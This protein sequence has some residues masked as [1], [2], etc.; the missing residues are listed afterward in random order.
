MATLGTTAFSHIK[1]MIVGYEEEPDSTTGDVA[2]EP[3]AV[4]GQEL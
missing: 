4:T 1:V 3:E 2:P